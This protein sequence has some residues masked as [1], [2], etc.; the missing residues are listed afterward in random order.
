MRRNYVRRILCLPSR[1]DHSLV[2][3]LPDCHG[4]VALLVM[5]GKQPSSKLLH[6]LR[7]ICVCWPPKRQCSISTISSPNT[8]A[9][10]VFQATFSHV[11]PS[12]LTS[13]TQPLAIVPWYHT[14]STTG[15]EPRLCMSGGL[16][17]LR[18]LLSSSAWRA[19]TSSPRGATTVGVSFLLEV[20]LSQPALLIGP[21]LITWA[22]GCTFGTQLSV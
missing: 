7:L 1:V 20:T 5:S 9:L 8:E 2:W 16:R 12:R 3:I 18:F 17:R 15:Y 22:L 11:S 21:G 10:L 6:T 14:I 13:T 19:H 4:I